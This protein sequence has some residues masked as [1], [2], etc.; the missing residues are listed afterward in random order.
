MRYVEAE[1][2]LFLMVFK[3]C[4]QVVC[5]LFTVGSDLLKH[6]NQ[7]R[8]QD[9]LESVWLCQANRAWMAGPY[10]DQAAC[11]L[12]ISKDVPRLFEYLVCRIVTIKPAI[13]ISFFWFTFLADIN[14]FKDSRGRSSSTRRFPALAVCTRIFSD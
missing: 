4:F 13:N 9:F 11:D 5:C 14:P 1:V 6:A 7:F 2:E 10:V 8:R 12:V 3:S